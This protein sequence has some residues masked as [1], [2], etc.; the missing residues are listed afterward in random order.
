MCNH[1]EPSVIVRASNI[2]VFINLTAGAGRARNYLPR[3]QRVFESSGI[4]AEFVM[5]HSAEELESRVQEAILRG[6]NLLI[7]A[8]GDGTFQALANAA[9]GADVLLGIIPV[10]G[11]N[12]FAAALGMPGDP[13]KAT[14]A[15][16]AGQVRLVDLVRVRTGDGRTR[17]YAGGGGVG[18]D[19]EAVRY[20]SGAYR[21][22]P[23]RIRYIA[24]ALTALAR[25]DS[26]GVRIDFPGSNLPSF[27]TQVLLAAALNSPTYGAGLRLAPDA[28]IDDGS[29]EVVMIEKL[30]K[31][32][33][34]TLL[35]R[36]MGSGEL[37]TSRVMRWR[38]RRVRFTTQQPCT[39]HG[40]GEILGPT[41]VEIE[42]VPRA[43]RV[44]VPTVS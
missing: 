35:P 20:A 19:A 25:F 21:Q 16:L 7:T 34:L 13:V 30:N 18:L 28:K 37:R 29:L 10:G 22:L 3:I 23:G 6:K 32:E 11:G 38:A 31:F 26:L 42:A 1:A 40:D 41:P 44:L 27:E 2:V 4:P 17:L 9:F 5:T 12:D 36:L 14:E 8:G 15:L 24:S 39:F 43:V 33:V